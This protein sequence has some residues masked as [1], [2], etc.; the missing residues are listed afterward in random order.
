MLVSP[1]RQRAFTLT[2]WYFSRCVTP[3]PSEAAKVTSIALPF[4]GLALSIQE[5]LRSGTLRSRGE[6]RFDHVKKWL[7][8]FWPMLRVE[9]G[10]LLEDITP[11]NALAN[12]LKPPYK[13]CLILT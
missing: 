3:P 4:F 1:K 7:W 5:E 12:D 13:E 9:G 2:Q 10:A 8:D 11:E 6:Q